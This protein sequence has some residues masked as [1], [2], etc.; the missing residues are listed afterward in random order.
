[1]STVPLVAVSAPI[2]AAY[3]LGLYLL[4]FGPGAVTALK[5]HGIW[6]LAGVIASPLVWW[7]AASVRSA[8]PGSWWADHVYSVEKQRRSVDEWGDDEAGSWTLP[9]G[10][11][12]IAFPLTIGIGVILLTL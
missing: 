11:A 5:G 12:F 3:V 1:M 10:A 8:K 4:V 6:L 9:V 2:A 7:Y